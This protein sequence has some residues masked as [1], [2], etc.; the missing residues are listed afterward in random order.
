MAKSFQLLSLGASS[1]VEVRMYADPITQSGDAPRATDTAVPFEVVAGIITD[2]V[3]DTTPYQWNWQNR[4]GANAQSP[5]NASIYV[6]VINPSSA[7]IS[8]ATVTIT[9]LALET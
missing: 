9:Y 4:I 2:V 8:G 5:Q 3:F 1:P 6:S 7:G